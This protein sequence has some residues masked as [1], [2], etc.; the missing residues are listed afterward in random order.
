MSD[1]ISLL[2][3]FLNLGIENIT[4]QSNKHQNKP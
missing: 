1:F 4:F 3:E 2:Y